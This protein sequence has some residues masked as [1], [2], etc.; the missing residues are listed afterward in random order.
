MNL[1][2]CCGNINIYSNGG[3]YRVPCRCLMEYRGLGF[4]MDDSCKN[5][6]SI[7]LGGF[8]R[9]TDVVVCALIHT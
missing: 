1:F 7:N 2:V 4:L 5:I 8:Y 6:E 9:V 3:I